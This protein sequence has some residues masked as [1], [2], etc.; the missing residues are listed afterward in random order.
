M[1]RGRSI[2]VVLAVVGLCLVWANPALSATYYVR[3]DGGS[4][5][6]CTGLVDA[7][8]LGEG[9]NQPCA[10][11]HPFWAVSP[12]GWNPTKMEGGD[13]LI[14]DGSDG[15]EYMMGYG[16]PNTHDTSK[17]YS[18][19]P[20]GC[21]MRSIPSGP[22]PAHPT[23]ILGKGWDFG[24]DSPP[25][26]WGTERITKILNLDGTS[27]VE[28]QCI[29]VTDHSDCQEHGPNPCNRS[30]F[31]F[32]DWGQ[33]GLTASDSDN[34]LLK[35]VNIH[36]MGYRG[37]YAGRLSNWTV[38]DSK[39]VS[40]PFV[41]WDG[42]ID[43]SDY[44]TGT[45]T[46]IRT[47]VKFNGCGETYPEQQPYNCYSQDQGGYGDGFGTG[48]TGGD[49]VFYECDIS[50][51]ASDGLDLLYHDEGGKI[52]IKRSRFE[53][54]AGNQVK[55]STSASISD[56][57]IIGNCG[58]FAGNPITVTGQ[59]NGFN[60]CRAGGDAIAIAAQKGNTWEFYNN[61]IYS[62]GNALA[63]IVDNVG[64]CDGSESFIAR[65]NIYKGDPYFNTPVVQSS[66]Y[67]DLRG[68][69][70]ATPLDTDYSIVYNVKDR[71]CPEGDHN[72]C[73]TDPLWEGPLSGDA[74]N[75]NLKVDSL[76]R[77]S[78]L[79]LEGKSGLDY[80]YYDRGES[81]DIGALEYGSVPVVSGPPAPEPEPVSEPE[82]EPPAEEEEP[83][84]EPEPISN[85]VQEPVVPPSVPEPTCADG[86][87]Y[88]TTQ[89]PCEWAGYYW[90]NNTCNSEPEAC[91]P[92]WCDLPLIECGQTPLTGGTDSCGNS[93]TKPS[94][95]WPN[96]I[97]PKPEPE[98][99]PEPIP[100]PEEMPVAQLTCADGIQ[101]CSTAVD[102][103]NQGYYW[104][105][106]TC[107]SEAAC[108]PTWC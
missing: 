85:I 51:N 27:N 21:Y 71:Y 17:C 79:F 13:T 106:D 7:A 73:S 33:T 4:P 59:V 97:E 86:I 95:E 53:G 1:K 58:Y 42:D 99:E 55:V 24:C 56:S 2:L 15:A 43:G 76:S 66:L 62:Q 77:N 61:T 94:E 48:F 87:Q 47:E 9:A 8:Y 49:W 10:F 92:T 5:T 29:E 12:V 84:P 74:W 40:N 35:N 6:Q 90:Y 91:V 16:A 39:I 37:V 31:P 20:Y 25:E 68:G 32:G 101:Y 28:I 44:N 34:V 41:G 104:Y 81:W 65:N 69:A 67:A 57:I 107:N 19:W 52:T 14:I 60:H 3:K 88:C 100:E 105:N 89:T 50:H 18:A 23:R 80:N 46:F 11:S 93:C 75:V 45:M 102:C 82:P 108:V 26:L 22:D 63:L 72:L 98:S 36:G 54:N 38:E 103:N 30:S 64:S 96:C 70:C 78:G 83:A